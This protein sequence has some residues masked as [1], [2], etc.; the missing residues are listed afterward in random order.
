MDNL[1]KLIDKEL[2]EL[3]FKVFEISYKKGK[4]NKLEIALEG[5][6]SFNIDKIVSATKIINPIVEENFKKSESYVLDV[7]GKENNYE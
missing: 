5:E 3:S 6:D 1:K 4:P 7:Y 2:E